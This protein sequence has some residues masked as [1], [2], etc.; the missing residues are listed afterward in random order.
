MPLLSY[1]S[2][3]FNLLLAFDNFLQMTHLRNLPRFAKANHERTVITPKNFENFTLGNY[4]RR[5]PLN[6][7]TPLSDQENEFCSALNDGIYMVSLDALV[8][9]KNCPV[10]IG[11]RCDPNVIVFLWAEVIIVSMNTHPGLHKDA[12]D[13]WAIYIP[14]QKYRRL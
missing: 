6:R 8:G 5:R 13:I 3:C 14:V 7:A 2:S 12:A 4:H 10:V 1:D 11:Y 9:G